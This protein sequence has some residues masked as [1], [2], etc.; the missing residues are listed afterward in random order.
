MWPTPPLLPV[1]NLQSGS[2]SRTA[3][4]WSTGLCSRC[5][6]PSWPPDLP[7]SSASHATWPGVR[8]MRTKVSGAGAFFSSSD[9]HVEAVAA[10]VRS[11]GGSCGR[12]HWQAFRQDR[13]PNS[14]A[15]RSNCSPG[16]TPLTRTSLPAP[17]VH[18]P[19][20]LGCGITGGAG[21]RHCKQGA[22]PDVQDSREF[23]CNP[24]GCV[25]RLHQMGR[26]SSASSHRGELDAES[27]PLWGC[28]A[29]SLDV[30]SAIFV[31]SSANATHAV[32][33]FPV[34]RQRVY[35]SERER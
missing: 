35:F 29:L 2:D 19:E 13:S 21:R 15:V 4:G 11:G 3:R 8:T 6:A 25:N 30:D 10:V 31:Q 20:R 23:R 24:R 32:F 27:L 12:L 1:F 7:L 9:W 26:Y 34:V 17:Q 14:S 33:V 16:M 5:R 28:V 22:C 18:D